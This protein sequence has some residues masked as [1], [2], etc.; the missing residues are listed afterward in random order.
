MSKQD[1]RTAIEIYAAE[2]VP[3]FSQAW[4]S[5]YLVITELVVG[6]NQKA[7]YR[8][9]GDADNVDLN[10]WDILGFQESV[11]IHLLAQELTGG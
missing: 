3:A 4:L 10:T 1:L 7:L 2:A 9:S 6:G 11:R 8:V 5:R